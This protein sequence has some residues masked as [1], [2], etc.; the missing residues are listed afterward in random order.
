MRLNPLAKWKGVSFCLIKAKPQGV[1]S[2]ATEGPYIFEGFY[3][4]SDTTVVVG[5]GRMRWKDN[6]NKV[7]PLYT[8]G[9]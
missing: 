1:M 7:V 4:D 2:T 9:V 6:V 3:G 5:D 8:G